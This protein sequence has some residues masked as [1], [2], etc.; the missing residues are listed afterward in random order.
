[1]GSGKIVGKARARFEN[2]ENGDERNLKI[3]GIGEMNPVYLVVCLLIVL[4]ALVN[5]ARRLD[6]SSPIVLVIGG[7]ILALFPR[8]PEVRLEPEI[9]FLVFLP[10]LLYWDALNSSW[11]DFRDNRRPIAFLAIGL[12]FASTMAVMLIAHFML[13]FP[14]PAAFVLGAVLGPTDTVAAAAIL[15]RFN[16]PRRL[17]SVL[18]GES[19]L[20]D[21]L[22]LV[23][24]ETAVRVT[25]TRM[26]VLGSI[27]IGFSL[28]AAGGV[29][30]GMTVGW[31]ML[32]IQR[33]TSD[34]LV[35]STIGLLT[36]YA[37][38]LPADALH[39][40]GVLAVVTAGL[41][42]G[43]EDPR[44]MSAKTR[45]QSIATWEVVT[46]LLN[47]L[48]FILIGLQ[49]RTMVESFS[50]ESLGSIIY[51]CLL[52]SGTVILV[53]ILW[54]FISTYFPRA[55]SGR[56]RARDLYPAWKEPV[57]ISWIGIRGGIS[58]AAALAIPT[59][60]ANG[61]PFPRRNE[62]LIFTFAVILVT[63]VLQGL[64]LPYLLRWLNLPADDAERAE[65]QRA[66]ETIAAVALQFLAST[67]KE[68]ETHRRAVLHLQD[69]YRKSAEGLDLAC[70]ACQ[71]NP[72]KR[73]L[74]QIDS[75]ER[76]LIRLQRAALIDL[77]DRG[78]ISDAVLRRFQVLL[79]LE[80]ARLEEQER[81]FHV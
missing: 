43:W 47:G 77:R 58:L 28:A 54:V 61:S 73:Y 17:M 40:S 31:A 9:V 39:V 36:G 69:S 49:L 7:F 35:R 5:V 78:R 16:L 13:R 42:L 55:W 44:V 24:Y 26:Y 12:V 68:D 29:V 63:L 10:P 72:E 67:T 46:F 6:I 18:R 15:E 48:L 66:R 59:S 30:I 38:Y 22:A 19:L 81:R 3:K 32:R 65:E 45:L 14:W 79:D 27:S 56:L 41:Y 50:Q 76:D 8:L 53:R 62:I 1:L 51:G 74:N 71:D 52:V 21:A 75:L 70:E 60:L 25:Q 4:A 34:P 80:E 37:A 57:L 20:N 33:L 64:S 2:E 11:R 23:L